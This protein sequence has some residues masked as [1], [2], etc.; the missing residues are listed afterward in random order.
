MVYGNV[1]R[2]CHKEELNMKVA[3][4][5]LGLIFTSKAH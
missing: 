5:E 2:V 1:D 4:E 3:R